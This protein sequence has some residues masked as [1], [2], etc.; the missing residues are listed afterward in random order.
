MSSLI[1]VSRAR[2]IVHIKM[3]SHA[4]F[5]RERI[6]RKH[7]SK[8]EKMAMEGNRGRGA[9]G[10]SYSWSKKRRRREKSRWQTLWRRPTLFLASHRLRSADSALPILPLRHVGNLPPPP[11]PSSSTNLLPR[12]EFLAGAY[13]GVREKRILHG[14]IWMA[15]FGTCVVDLETF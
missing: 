7:S 6:H 5:L 8:M 9:I 15:R 14:M 3:K 12:I 1:C 2:S 4:A 11:L 10:D 13:L